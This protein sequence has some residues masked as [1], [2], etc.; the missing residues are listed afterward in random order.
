M[1]F[2]RYLWT[3]VNDQE[4]LVRPI[5]WSDIIMAAA[6]CESPLCLNPWH[7]VRMTRN[8]LAE[9]QRENMLDRSASL[10]AAQAER[11][12]ERLDEAFQM[13]VRQC[14][15]AYVAGRCV[16]L[17]TGRQELADECEQ[18]AD[19]STAMAD[20]LRERLLEKFPKWKDAFA[21]TPSGYDTRDKMHKRR[22]IVLHFWRTYPEAK[23]WCDQHNACDYL[24]DYTWAALG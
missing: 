14:F 2:R 3:Q 15:P 10:Y 19:K 13:R 17:G 4:D 16:L 9:M 23:V 22:D 12:G 11:Q 21:A 20:E 1:S 8:E 18:R 7:Q 24:Q 6:S 5:S